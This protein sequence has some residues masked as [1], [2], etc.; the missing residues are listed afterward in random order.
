MRLP[1]FLVSGDFMPRRPPRPCTAPGCTSVQDGDRCDR[2]RRERNRLKSRERGKTAVRGYDA[3]WRKVRRLKLSRQ[4]LCETCEARGQ[5]TPAQM[6]HHLVPIRA[7]WALRLVLL[8]L[9]SVCIACH[10]IE[11]RLSDDRVAA[12]PEEW[13]QADLARVLAEEELTRAPRGV[14]GV[15]SSPPEAPVTAGPA[16][17]SR[18]QFEDSGFPGGR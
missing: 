12:G 5:T 2:H 4:P 3:R 7:S 13:T 15:E 14:R 8:N 11:E 6:V 10:P 17:F 1:P 18:G 16:S 9:K